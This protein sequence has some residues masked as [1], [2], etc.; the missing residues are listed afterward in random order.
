MRLIPLTS[1]SIAAIGYKEILGSS[2]VAVM[3]QQG[4]C[5]IY[6][7]V[8][9]S[10]FVEVIMDEESQGKAFHQ[11]IKTK[12]AWRKSDLTEIEKL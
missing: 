5:Y 8:P 10:V 1:S 9:V 7:N 11:K 6:E 3:F 2:K 12:Y 4:G